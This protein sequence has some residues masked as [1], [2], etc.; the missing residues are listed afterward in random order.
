MY[1]INN[2]N[3]YTIK[4]IS[5]NFQ[6]MNLFLFFVIDDFIDFFLFKFNVVINLYG[7]FFN[8]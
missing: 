1:N 4:S 8:L 7:L 6:R 3:I 2:N 5:V